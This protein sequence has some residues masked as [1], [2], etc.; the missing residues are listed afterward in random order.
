VRESCV[1]SLAGFVLPGSA[2]PV[3]IGD[4][5]ALEDIIAVRDARGPGST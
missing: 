1:L 4:K 2:Y 5:P 3:T